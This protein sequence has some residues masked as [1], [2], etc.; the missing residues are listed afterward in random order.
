MQKYKIE[1]KQEVLIN[2][3]QVPLEYFVPKFKNNQDGALQGEM[4]IKDL[5]PFLLKMTQ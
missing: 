1:N 5:K 3:L 2:N 4:F